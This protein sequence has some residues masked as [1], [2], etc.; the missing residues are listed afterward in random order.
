M[1]S[2]MCAF[3]GARLSPVDVAYVGAVRLV[4]LGGARGSRE[5]DS[6][7]R[8]FRRWESAARGCDMTWALRAAAAGRGSAPQGHS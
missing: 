8:V 5:D 6:L 2:V 3:G 7:V 1:D 4:V